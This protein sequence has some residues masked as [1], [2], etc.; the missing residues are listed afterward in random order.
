MNNYFLE[1][2]VYKIWMEVI[3][4]LSPGSYFLVQNKKYSFEN[5]VCSREE[6][7]YLFSK[8]FLNLELIYAQEYRLFF[9][10]LTDAENGN[11]INWE[12]KS[13]ELK[14]VRTLDE[15]KM[16]IQNWLDFIRVEI[17]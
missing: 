15:L 11:L 7:K 4:F 13:P 5:I 10:R 9:A 12:N 16:E 2:P 17:K 6:V 3:D 1:T 8:E 14:K